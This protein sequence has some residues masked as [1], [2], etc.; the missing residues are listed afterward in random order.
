[1]SLFIDMRDSFSIS[2]W[3]R[4][5]VILE[6]DKEQDSEPSVQDAYN[7]ILEV[8]KKHARTLND[9]D[10]FEL[11]EKLKSFFNKAI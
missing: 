10:A 6:E 11:H 9:D 2:D 4:R 1:M 3:H 7:E 8:L 5:F